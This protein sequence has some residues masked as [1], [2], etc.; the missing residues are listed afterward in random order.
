M[1]WSTSTDTTQLSSTSESG[2]CYGMLSQDLRNPAGGDEHIFV[3]SPE[4]FKISQM[5]TY[6]CSYARA[7]AECGITSTNNWIVR[8]DQPILSLRGLL[9]LHLY[10]QGNLQISVGLQIQEL[11]TRR[12]VTCETVLTIQTT[13]HELS[14]FHFRPMKGVPL[15]GY[16]AWPRYIP[17]ERT[18]LRICETLS[19]P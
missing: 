1:M 8:A 19:H 9:L 11:S 2:Q 7:F 10:R 14:D 3:S 4:A 5:P 17:R 18:S 13:Q 16:G 6:C 15:V 12:I